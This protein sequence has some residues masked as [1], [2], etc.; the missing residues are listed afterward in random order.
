MMVNMVN[1][2]PAKHG[3]VSMAIDSLLLLD[4]N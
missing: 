2:M 3:H 1:V 4:S